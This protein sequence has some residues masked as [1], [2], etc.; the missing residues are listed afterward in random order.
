MFLKVM[1][2]SPSSVTM[3]LNKSC[4]HFLHHISQ[5]P[6]PGKVFMLAKEEQNKEPVL[7]L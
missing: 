4:L 6:G 3:S 2:Y 1:D 5:T 7:A